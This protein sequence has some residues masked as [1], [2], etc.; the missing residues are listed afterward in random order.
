MR[1]IWLAGATTVSQVRQCL[2]PARPLAYTTVLT[3]LDRLTKKGALTRSRY[4]R[5]HVYQPVLSFEASRDAALREVLEFYF[6]G[7]KDRLITY[8]EHSLSTSFRSEAGQATPSQVELH[9]CLL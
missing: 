5:A 4:G 1:M 8:V 9:D 3:I 2:S 6:E 7:S